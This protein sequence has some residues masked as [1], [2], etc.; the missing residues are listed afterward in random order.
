M[1]I[2]DVLREIDSL[3]IDSPGVSCSEDTVSGGY[4]A[5]LRS[6]RFRLVARRAEIETSE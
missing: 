3:N 5:Q 1:A 2:A 6:I 4:A